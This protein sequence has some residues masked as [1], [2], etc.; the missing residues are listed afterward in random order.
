[1][2]QCEFCHAPMLS[3][4]EV[5]PNCGRQQPPYPPVLPG[6]GGKSYRGWALILSGLSVGFAILGIAMYIQAPYA[7]I[8]AYVYG[9]PNSYLTTNKPA[10]LTFMDSPVYS[11][12]GYL[13]FFGGI[14][15]IL[16]FWAWVSYTR[17]NRIDQANAALLRSLEHDQARN[18]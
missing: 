9:D 8:A 11:G 6:G 17:G 3:I 14:A 10:W 7:D 13:A 15:L 16:I 18:K 2:N 5:C 1:M 12:W 4:T